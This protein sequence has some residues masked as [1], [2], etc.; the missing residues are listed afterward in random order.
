MCYLYS[1]GGHVGVPDERDGY[2]LFFGT[3]PLASD[4]S[5][6]SILTWCH[7]VRQRTQFS[8]LRVIYIT[9]VFHCRIF[10]RISAMGLIACM[11]TPTSMFADYRKIILPYVQDL[12]ND[13]N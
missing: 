8:S 3:I 9:R 4:S 12:S 2:I 5:S 10:W 1:T 13:S 6:S 11:Y 7:H